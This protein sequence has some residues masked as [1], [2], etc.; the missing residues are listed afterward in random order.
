ME[1]KNWLENIGFWL[2]DNRFRKTS[3]PFPILQRLEGKIL[4]VPLLSMRTDR[5]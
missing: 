1:L 3:A 2:T 4:R 5:G